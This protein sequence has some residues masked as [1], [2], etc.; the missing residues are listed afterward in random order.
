MPD[1]IYQDIGTHTDMTLQGLFVTQFTHYWTQYRSDALLIK[2][3]VLG[4]CIATTAKSAHAM[5]A[6]I[7][8]L[9]RKCTPDG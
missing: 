2:L 7:H 4:L 1:A 6:L 3:F 5:Y 8:A 9:I